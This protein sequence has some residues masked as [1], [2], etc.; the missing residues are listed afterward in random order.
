VSSLRKQRQ[1]CFR[2]FAYFE[3]LLLMQ[4]SG[5][6]MAIPLAEMPHLIVN[7]AAFNEEVMSV[8]M[9]PKRICYNPSGLRRCITYGEAFVDKCSR[10]GVHSGQQLLA[11]SR[12]AANIGF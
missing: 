12:S 7:L 2:F 11:A 8:M 3:E 1:N 6:S 4:L 10:A 5:F 9:T